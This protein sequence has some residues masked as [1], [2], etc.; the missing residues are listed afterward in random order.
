[1]KNKYIFATYA[2]FALSIISNANAVPFNVY[3]NSVTVRNIATMQHSIATNTI[4]TFEGTM[5]AALGSRAHF[6]LSNINKTDTSHAEYGIMPQYGQMPVYGEYNDD[7][8]ATIRGRNG[9]D[10]SLPTFNSLWANWQHFDDKTKFDGFKKIDTDYDVITVGLAG[11]HAKLGSGISQWGLYGGYAGSTQKNQFLDLD[12]NGGYMGV[13]SGH[14]INNFNISASVNVGA[15]FSDADFEY[16]SNDYSN[17]WLGAT[18]HGAYNIAIDDTLTLQ[19]GIYAGYTWVNS[20]DYTIGATDIGNS[21]LNS[22]ELTPEIRAIKHIGSG[23]FGS[24]NIRYVAAWQNGG[25]TNI[26]GTHIKDLDS[27]NYAEYGIGLE[28]SIDR[29]NITLHIGR[30]DGGQT[31]WN[32]G[33]SFKYIF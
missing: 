22:F 9:G 11:A 16:E 32:G 26:N 27:D 28:K 19:P 13:Y 21:N 5:A 17:A 3:A 4:Q 15:M 14:S 25:D 20:D 1:M 30:R 23:W 24:A 18:I 31:G 2:I 6:N 12:E 29:F 10:T 8:S 7:G 33:T